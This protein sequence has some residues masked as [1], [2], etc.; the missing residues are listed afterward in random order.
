MRATIDYCY[1]GWMMQEGHATTAHMMTN[2]II[3]DI[4]ALWRSGLSIRVSGCQKLQMMARPGT[5][6]FIA[7]PHGNGGC[8][9]VNTS[10]RWWVIMGQHGQHVEFVTEFTYL[11]TVA[12]SILTPVARHPPKNRTIVCRQCIALDR[13]QI[14]IL[15]LNWL[16]YNTLCV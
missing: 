3:F 12:F 7:V 8:E 10:H 15:K 4:R 13:Q 14:K 5:G 9:K 6:W 1:Y 11:D 2:N 16:N